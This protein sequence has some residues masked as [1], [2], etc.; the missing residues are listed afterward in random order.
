MAI[1]AFKKQ[2]GWHP[3]H[4]A[5]QFPVADQVAIGGEIEDKLATDV[6]L[7]EAPQG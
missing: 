4:S 1:G 2:L 6:V 3:S 7:Q 5:S